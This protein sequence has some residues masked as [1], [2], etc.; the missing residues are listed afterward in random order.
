MN[1]PEARD[2]EARV[3]SLKHRILSDEPGDRTRYDLRDL[4]V[5]YLASSDGPLARSAKMDLGRAISTLRDRPPPT[6]AA[7]GLELHRATRGLQRALASA[8]PVVDAESHDGIVDAL[9]RPMLLE[10]ARR[11]V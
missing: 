4:I 9:T 3:H 7:L 6:W 5:E 8:D 2:F 11:I 1:A 10:A